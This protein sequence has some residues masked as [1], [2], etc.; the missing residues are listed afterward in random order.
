MRNN[1]VKIIA[2]YLPQFHESKENNEFWGEGY[3]EW[4]NVRK[5]R[6]VYWQHYQPRIPLDGDYYDLT[7]GTKIIEH[8]NIALK[9]GIYGF[10]FYHY[11]FGNKKQILQRPL[12]NVLNNFEF[13]IPFCFCWANETW[14]R[15]WNGGLGEKEVLMEQVYSG[16][17][18][19]IDHINYLLP[20]FK[21]DKYIKKN[22]CPMFLLFDPQNVPYIVKDRMFSVWE[23]VLKQNGFNGIE[24]I[25]V[26][27]G[28]RGDIGSKFSNK[29]V[30]FEPTK[31]RRESAVESSL[32]C[33]VRKYLMKY[34]SNNIIKHFLHHKISYSDTCKKILSRNHDTGYYRSLFVGYDDTPRRGWRST[35]YSGA[36]PERYYCFLKESINL[37][38]EE[39]NEFLFLFAWNEWG[40]GGYLEPDEKYRFKYLEATKKALEDAD[41]D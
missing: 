5:A 27:V 38:V 39:N 9:Y 1:K 30:D 11:W 24:L 31:T 19:W 20:F 3:T 37:S 22:N 4:V 10:C 33:D 7:D 29:R 17:K 6:P 23:K 14:T 15:T 28:F 13:S 12:D 35:I 32:Y 34:E 21:N 40:E 41:C 36:T 8:G 18:D 26:D 2:Y 25:N 16:E